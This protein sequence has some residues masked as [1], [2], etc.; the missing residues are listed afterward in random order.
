MFLTP[1]ILTLITISIFKLYQSVFFENRS[2]EI[3][4]RNNKNDSDNIDDSENTISINYSKPLDTSLAKKSYKFTSDIE[5]EII[6][7]LK[8]IIE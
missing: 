2:I 1:I 7:T 4:N 3:K 5:K 8:K 6:K